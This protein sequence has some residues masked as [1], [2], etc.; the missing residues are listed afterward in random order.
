MSIFR[1]PKGDTDTLEK[2]RRNFIWSKEYNKKAFVGLVGTR[3][4]HQ[5]KWVAKVIRGI[6][7]L[8]GRHWSCF[9]SSTSKGLKVNTNAKE[10]VSWNSDRKC[11]VLEFVIDNRFS[12]SLI[13]D[14]FELLGHI[15]CDGPFDWNKM[16]PFKI[17]CFM[18]R[19]KQDRIPSAIV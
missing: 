8:D 9:T 13:G 19:A 1:V 5:K 12:V 18:W 2:I 15:V 6:H 11:W 10:I 17:L 4:L 14:R 16:I 3:L 7:N